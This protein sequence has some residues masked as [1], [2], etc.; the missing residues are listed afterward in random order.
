MQSHRFHTANL[1]VRATVF[2]RTYASRARGCVRGTGMAGWS[3]EFGNLG[4]RS[5]SWVAVPWR[6]QV[7]SISDCRRLKNGMYR[8]AVSCFLPPKR[9]LAWVGVGAGQHGSILLAMHGAGKVRNIG[10]IPAGS[11]GGV[12]RARAARTTTTATR[13]LL[14]TAKEEDP[15]SHSP[16]KNERF[17]C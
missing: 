2:M 13:H 14:Y 7:C 16:G 17:D 11:A 10:L 15:S 3:G 9:K 1:G 12:Q 5:Y 6:P 8:A 4:K